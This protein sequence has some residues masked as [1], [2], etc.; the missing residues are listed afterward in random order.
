M[1]GHKHGSCGFGFNSCMPDCRELLVQELLTTSVTEIFTTLGT[2][3]ITTLGAWC[4]DAPEGYRMAYAP[5]LRHAD[6]LSAFPQGSGH[7]AASAAS[8]NLL[9]D[10]LTRRNRHG[11]SLASPSISKVCA[12]LRTGSGGLCD[13]EACGPLAS[14]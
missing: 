2:A 8:G 10:V 5:P 1:A 7:A 14:P 11:A 6:Q 9:G 12:G 13:G 3:W 4:A